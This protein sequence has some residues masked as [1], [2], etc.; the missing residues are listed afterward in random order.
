MR[1]GVAAAALA[2]LLTPALALA[3]ELLPDI[4]A[5]PPEAV[6]LAVS[7]SGRHLLRFTQRFTNV[8]PGPLRVHGLPTAEEGVM[9]GYQEILND[10]GEVVR[11]LPISSIIFHPY[12]KHWH[13]GDIAA[14]QLRRG[15]PWGPVVAQNGKISYCLVDQT[16]DDGYAGQYWPPTY[17]NCEQP[18]QGLNPGY[19]DT[20]E[21]D[22]YDQWV[23]A[24]DLQD[25]VFFLVVTGDPSHTYAEAD[26]GDWANNLAW[27]KVELSK[28]VRQV[29]VM[30]PDE[31]LLRLDGERLQ[32]PAPTVVRDGVTLAA[33]RLAE[34]LGAAVTWDGER[35]T[36][37]RG[38]KRLTITPGQSTALVDGTPVAM[39]AAAVMADD[40]LLVP[41][42]FLAEQLGATVSYDWQESTVAISSR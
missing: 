26:A 1:Q 19:I 16:H 24:T 32:L 38:G 27:V 15:S 33:V 23:D 10:A 4:K 37:T 11:R 8:G 18:S 30:R 5:L 40:R 25:G 9:Q 22:L 6:S 35:V 14:Y 7:D 34:Q 42:R 2:L 13:A 29:R 3:A 31:V 28:G 12:H 41:V 20:Y 17:L 36:V 39:G 21:S